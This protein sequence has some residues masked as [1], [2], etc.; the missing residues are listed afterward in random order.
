MNRVDVAAEG[1]P[2]P[3]WAEAAGTFA[4]AACDALSCENWDVSVLFCDD[5]FI[6]ELNRRF[7]GKDEPTDVLSFPLG[8]CVIEGGE[9]RW[10]SGDIVISLET[11]RSN[12]KT[13]GVSEDEELRR[14]LLHGL[15]HLKGLDHATNAPDEAMLVL[16]ESML[17]GG[18]LPPSIV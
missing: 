13:F 1:L 16:Q 7:R 4:A 6:R 17:S 8:E 14:L 3:E 10:A 5:I 9:E 15:L 18:G 2:L 11:L 12:C